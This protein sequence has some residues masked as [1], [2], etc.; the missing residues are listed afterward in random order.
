MRDAFFDALTALGAE[1]ERIWA[2]TGDLGI[3]LFEPFA[4]AA[5]GRFLNV[6][7]AEQNMVGIAAG[8][9]Y[10]GKVPFAYSIAPFITSRAHDQIRVDVALAN[11]NVKLV[12]VGGG[13]A[14]GTLGPTHHA[15]EDVALMRVLPN[16]TVLTPGD[17]AEARGAARAAA[18][19]DGPVY[20]RLGK[21]GEPLLLPDEPFR[22]GRARAVREGGDLT[23]VTCGPILG[24]ALAAAEELA[25]DGVDAAVLHFPTVKPFDVEAIATALRRSPLLVSVEEHLD[26]G[27]L[28]SAV[29]EAIAESG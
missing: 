11:A 23:L 27:G 26:V 14:Y 1:D 18:E 7:I 3:G 24:E 10:S 19:L 16:M 12:G 20:L 9:A 22:V 28:G 6:G 13:V 4:A 8:L 29:A 15:I 5:P 17:P 21:N 2:L 25:A